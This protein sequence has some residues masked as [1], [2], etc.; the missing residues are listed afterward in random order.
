MKVSII[1][2]HDEDNYGATLQAYATYRAIRELGHN[3]EI[4]N[5]HMAHKDSLPTKIVFALKRYRFNCFRKKYMPNKTRLYTSVSQLREEPPISDVYLVGSDQTWNPIISKEYALAYFLDFGKE[6]QK[7]ISYASSFGQSI[8]ED[9]VYAK[10]E[11]V[12]RLLS[13]FST[14]L[15]R[16][17]KA[18][19]MCKNEFGFEAKQVVDPVLLFPSY[20]ELTGDIQQT[21]D[22]VVYK[23]LNDSQFY[24]RAVDLGIL[25]DCT[26]RSVGSMRRPK[27]V[28]S[29]YPEI[30]EKWISNIASAKYVFTDS[31]HGTVLSLLYHKQFVIYVGDKRKMSRIT[32]LLGILGLTDRIFS[33]EDNINSI[34]EKLSFPIDYSHVDEVLNNQRALSFELLNNA[35]GNNVL[36]K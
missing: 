23:I 15:V 7:R 29:S 11:V 33:N 19:E 1:T 13:R 9:S 35:I 28:K 8:W 10:K 36:W 4:I 5:L 3:P 26:V 25:L 30:I 32:S 31:F 6:N 14:I 22:I 27:G 20:P 2:Y 21:N 18:V 17:D 24:K 16:E 34:A 12:K